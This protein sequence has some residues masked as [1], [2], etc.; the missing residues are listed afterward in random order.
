VQAKLWLQDAISGMPKFPDD[1][2]VD[3]ELDREIHAAPAPTD[4]RPAA[5]EVS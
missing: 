3:Q 2:L 1:R 5:Q 4:R